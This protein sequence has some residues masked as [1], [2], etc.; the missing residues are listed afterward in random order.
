MLPSVGATQGRH[1]RATWTGDRK[2]VREAL[3]GR[4]HFTS[5]GIYGSVQ[6]LGYGVGGRAWSRDDERLEIQAELSLGN[7]Y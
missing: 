3:G 5:R 7:K 2:D 4:G 6:D 1:A